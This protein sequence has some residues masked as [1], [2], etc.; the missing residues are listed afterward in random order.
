MG[1]IYRK[2]IEKL[3]EVELTTEEKQRFNECHIL[4]LNTIGVIKMGCLHEKYKGGDGISDVR[5]S[6]N[7]YIIRVSLYERNMITDQI[8]RTID[9][10]EIPYRNVKSVSA[11]NKT[12]TWIRQGTVEYKNGSA[13]KGAVIG[14]VIAGTPGA[15]LGA[16]ISANTPKKVVTPTSLHSSDNHYFKIEFS[17]GV[18]F[19]IDD[20]T[21]L[22]SS[23]KSEGVAFQRK[24]DQIA[25]YIDNSFDIRTPQG[26]CEAEKVKTKIES[27]EKEIESLESE[28]KE[29]EAITNQYAHSLFGAKAKMKREAKERIQEIDL[30]IPR[31][32][33]EKLSLQ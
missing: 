14:G 6:Y 23:Q 29:K 21:N 2:D 9:T 31:L 25:N 10:V 22:T 7:Q 32:K 11:D 19:E 24:A 18:K 28:R 4:G 15:V 16:A 13:L 26:F 5:L 17:N 27:L 1:L 20:L 30:K 8:I 12:I 33:E 3:H